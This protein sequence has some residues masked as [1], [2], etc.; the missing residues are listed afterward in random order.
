M[1]LCS[2]SV[3]SASTYSKVAVTHV[4]TF[5]TL[6]DGDVVGVTIAFSGDDGGG[7][8]NVVEDTTPQLGG[9]LDTNSKFISHAQ[10]AAI[11]SVAGD[12]NIWTNFDGN[13]VHIT[14]ANAITD[15]GTPKSAGDSM[16]VIFDGASSVVDSATIT[17]A[18]N[19]NYQAAANDLALVYALSTS[20]FLFMPFPNS[21]LSPVYDTDTAKTDVA[22]TFSAAQ[23]GSITALAD[24]ANISVDLSANNHF[25]VTLGGNRTLDNPSNIVA[26]TS[27]SI[28]ITQDGA[29]SRT[30]AYGGYYDFAAGAAPTLTTTAS[31]VDR[32]DYI[33]RTA[34]SLHCVF[35]GD[36]S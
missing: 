19:T 1:F 6:S 11:A 35:T 24:G 26:G 20:T 31:K 36:L 10:G 9:F 21:G 32:I 17:V 5:G 22:N 33:A 16:W 18:G 34:T 15:F 3:V 8:A 4:A 25:S 12:T 7:M 30:L 27:G 23:S 13:T 28:F 2:G 29:G 14:G